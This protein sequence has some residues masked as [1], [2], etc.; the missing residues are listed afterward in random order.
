MTRGPGQ[1]PAGNCRFLDD[2]QSQGG[3]TELERSV[4]IE[5]WSVRQG[6]PAG[7]AKSSVVALVTVSGSERSPMGRRWRMSMDIS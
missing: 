6:V 5:N 4:S 2:Q 3:P 1:R 7:T